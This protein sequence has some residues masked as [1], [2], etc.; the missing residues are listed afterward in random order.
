MTQQPIRFETLIERYHD[1]IH[2]YLWRL[3]RND[4]DAQDATQEVFIRA[5]QAFGRLRP[6]SNHRAWLYKIATHC[7]CTV[8][9]RRQR[10]T[11]HIPF[12][13]SAEHIAA[14][15]PSPPAQTAWN[16]T[17]ASLQRA[18]AA[19]PLKQQQALILR[20]IHELEYP[21]IAQALHCSPASARANV[22]Q[23]LRSLRQTLKDKK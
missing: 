11:Q 9:K 19:L 23:A 4:A 17:L 8:L 15:T 21:E 12:D 7:A 1:E 18:I 13:D 16:E 6:N 10:H 14:P 5:Y 2:S 22:Y 20:H 3:L